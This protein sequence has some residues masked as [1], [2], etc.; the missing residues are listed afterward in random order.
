MLGEK[1]KLVISKFNDGVVCWIVEWRINTV[2][3]LLL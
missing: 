1:V 3:L 2:E